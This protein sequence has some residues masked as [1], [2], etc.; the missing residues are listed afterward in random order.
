MEEWIY[1][2]PG[3][4]RVGYFSR[5]RVWAACRQGADSSTALRSSFEGN[6]FCS[7]SLDVRYEKGRSRSSHLRRPRCWKGGGC[8]EEVDP[9]RSRAVADQW[10]DDR[11]GF[12]SHG[13]PLR[14]SVRKLFLGKHPL[15]K[16]GSVYC[17][18]H[19]R[20]SWVRRKI[21]FPAGT[22]EELVSSP[23]FPCETT[24][25]FSGFALKTTVSPAWLRV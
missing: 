17:R 18:I 22:R 6:R 14:G 10:Q 4:G 19:Q 25:N 21:S 20:A 5:S 23:T 12:V 9:G 24:S 1:H 11:L 13:C 16:L 2:R 15:A 7:R 3:H 8:A